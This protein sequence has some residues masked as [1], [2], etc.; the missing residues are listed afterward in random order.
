MALTTTTPVRA[1]NNARIEK[2]HAT[3]SNFSIDVAVTGTTNDLSGFDFFRYVITDATGKKLYQEDTARQTGVTDRA[4][5]YN[6]AYD[7]DGVADGA[8]VANPIRFSVVDIDIVGKP[9]D[10]ASQI[11]FNAACLMQGTPAFHLA[12][13]LPT[14]VPG[15]LRGETMLY[16]TPST[17]YPLGIRVDARREFT[18]LYRTGD[19][20]WVALF[21]GGENLV[22]APGN[23]FDGDTSRVNVQP[24]RIDRSQQVTGAVIPGPALATAR[25]NYTSRYRTLP[26]LAGRIIGRIPYTTIVP[27]YGRS[28]NSGWVFI[29]YNGLGG[30]IAARLVTVLGVAL[31]DLPIVG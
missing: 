7:A 6:L 30:W 18:A 23:S 5:V 16:A 13:L 11:E 27:V 22:W 26:S 4:F 2:F 24:T 28:A 20:K 15:S 1:S 10:T 21:V 17:D 8:P 19:S 25:V 14:G 29:Q 9:V 12:D 31:K 3:C